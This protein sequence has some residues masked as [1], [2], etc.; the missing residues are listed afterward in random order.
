MSC[1]L[2]Y[3]TEEGNPEPKRRLNI[4]LPN[5][6]YP[7]IFQRQ[8]AKDQEA[9]LASMETLEDKLDTPTDG[10]ENV[11]LDGGVSNHIFFNDIM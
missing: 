11:K 2:M 10:M 7:K 5:V 6:K 4:K 3:I 9:T 1:N 8:S